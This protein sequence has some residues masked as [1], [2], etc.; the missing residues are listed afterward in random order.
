MDT[1]LSGRTLPIRLGFRKTWFICSYY[2]LP[3]I[4]YKKW[5]EKISDMDRV[6]YMD[7]KVVFNPFPRSP[8]YMLVGEFTSEF[9]RQ[10]RSLEDRVFFGCGRTG[11]TYIQNRVKH[12]RH[13]SSCSTYRLLST[14][15]F[16]CSMQP[17]PPLEQSDF[18]SPT[19]HPQGLANDHPSSR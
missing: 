8:Y 12:S 5:Y 2:R 19:R 11:K 1:R 10:M 9:D 4:Y 7:G 18:P 17:P 15:F 14:C 16:L 13:R 6:I 3:N